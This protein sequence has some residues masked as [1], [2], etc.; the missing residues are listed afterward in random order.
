[1]SKNEKQTRLRIGEKEVQG[2]KNFRDWAYNVNPAITSISS[3]NYGYHY[4]SDLY[5]GSDHKKV[6]IK[7][8]PG[9]DYN[10]YDI[11]TL[12]FQKV[13]QIPSADP[14]SGKPAD[15]YFF[16]YS[17][18]IIVTASRD[19][20]DKFVR[21]YGLGAFTVKTVNKCEMDPSQGKENQIQLAIPHNEF[22]KYF[23]LYKGTTRVK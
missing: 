1:M 14:E 7:Y 12:N 22:G 21:E 10:K 20:L 18:D 3:T 9:Q 15:I 2:F 17:D 4:D 6:E 23:R 13:L 16:Q 8:M 19:N 5:I 11:I